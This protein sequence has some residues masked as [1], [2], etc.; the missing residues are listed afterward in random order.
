MTHPKS[1]RLPV[2]KQVSNLVQFFGRKKKKH[3]WRHSAGGIHK[4]KEEMLE[5][6]LQEKLIHMK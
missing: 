3:T 5:N 4:I 1:Q 6:G 2:P